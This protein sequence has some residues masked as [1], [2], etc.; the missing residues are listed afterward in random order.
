MGID[1]RFGSSFIL[2]VDDLTDDVID[3][4]DEW[5]DEK[6]PLT[7]FFG[8]IIE[9]NTEMCDHYIEISLDEKTRG[10]VT[11]YIETL[12]PFLN[13]CAKY[14]IYL[15]DSV[16]YDMAWGDSESGVVYISSEE[17]IVKVT[18]ITNHGDVQNHNIDWK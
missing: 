14:S 16:S 5:I 2:Y 8:W 4:L 12:I 3:H 7:E 11:D 17:K 18:G 1:V 13:E 9:F 15:Q 6:Y 10:G